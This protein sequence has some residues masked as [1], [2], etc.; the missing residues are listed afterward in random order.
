MARID[1]LVARISDP[2]LR[3]EMTAAVAD[4]KRHQR[5][6]LVFEEHVPETTALASLPVRPGSLVQRRD[7]PTA[8]SLYRVISVTDAG[9]A[10]ITPIDGGNS[11]MVA[12]SNLLVVKRFGEPIYPALTPLGAIRRGADDRPHHAVINGEN[13]HALQ[14]LLYLYEGQVDCIYIDP[15]YNTGARDWKYNN[16]YV[17]ENDSWRHSKWLSMMEKRLRLTKRLLKKDGVLIVTIDEHEVHHLGMLLEGMFPEYLRYMI[18]DVIS[19]QG[20]DKINFSRVEE[21]V[22]FCCPDTGEEIIKGSAIDFLPDQDEIEFHPDAEQ[23][24]DPKEEDNDHYVATIKGNEEDIAENIRRRGSQSHRRDR[25]NMFY[26]IFIDEERR[27]VVRAGTPIKLDEEPMFDYIEGLRPIWPIDGNGDHRRWR[28]GHMRMQQLID[29]GEIKL[30]QYNRERNSWA[31]NR[32]ER[33]MREFKKLKTVWRHTSHAA[34]SHGSGLL[35]KLL[36]KS[37]FSYSG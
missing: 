20:N 19:A 3:A 33:K 1:D 30:G 13:Y 12:A 31:I 6:G 25:P 16:R 32:V 4:L 23:E 17:D 35:E 28:W 7:D 2:A 27:V 37:Q 11:E 10:T 9:E 14:L 29:I 26:P 24:K 22:F 18:T 21:H 8:R 36:G 34:G 5:F 15:P